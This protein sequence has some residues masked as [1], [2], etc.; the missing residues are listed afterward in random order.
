M[1]TIPKR[2]HLYEK[3]RVASIDPK[4][5]KR[6]EFN[7]IFEAADTIKKTRPIKASRSALRCGIFKASNPKARRGKYLGLVWET[8]GVNVYDGLGGLQIRPI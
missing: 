3:F 1:I 8:T 5:K 6:V 4:T 7:D 2:D